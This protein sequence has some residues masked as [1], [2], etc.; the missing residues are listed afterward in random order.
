MSKFAE[1]NSAYGSYFGLNPPARYSV[2]LA[3]TI[4]VTVQANLPRDAHI[5]THMIAGR[6]GKYQKN[7]MHVQGISCWAYVSD[8]LTSRP[9]NIGP[10]GQAVEA[11]QIISLIVVWGEHL[12]SWTDWIDTMVNETTRS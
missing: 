1:I 4:S 11:S 3:L 5:L 10:Y 6:K 2:K 7:V 12:C 9:A 8:F